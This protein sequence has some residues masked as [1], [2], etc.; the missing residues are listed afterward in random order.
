MKDRRTTWRMVPDDYEARVVDSDG[1][2]L[3][4]RIVDISERGAKLVLSAPENLTQEFT[5]LLS[6]DGFIQRRCRSVWRSDD[7]IGV[8]FTEITHDERLYSEVDHLKIA[9]TR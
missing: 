4:A 8:E 3:P 7:Q 6:P 1:K 5:L 9:L 2:K